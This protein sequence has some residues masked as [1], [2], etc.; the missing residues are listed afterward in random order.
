MKA[1]NEGVGVWHALAF[2]CL[3][4]IYIA[5]FAIIK[6]NISFANKF[7]RLRTFLIDI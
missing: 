3:I 4:L 6:S 7:M 5:F 1:G 2:W